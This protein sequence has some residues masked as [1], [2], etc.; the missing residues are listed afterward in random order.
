MGQIKERARFRDMGL[1]SALALSTAA[2]A[3]VGVTAA[4]AVQG[5][6]GELRNA[7]M[8]PYLQDYEIAPGVNTYIVVG[9]PDGVIGFI[10]NYGDLIVLA[11]MGLII[12][13]AIAAQAV[14]FYR[15]KLKRPLAVL[16]QASEKIAESDLD[17][18]VS[19]DQRDELGQLCVSF[20]TM[21]GAL[22]KN[23]REMWRAAEERRRINAAFSHDLRTPL[24]VLRGY[25]DLLAACI[26]LGKY[27]PEK[28]A[29][30][31]GAMSVQVNRLVRYTECMSALQRLEDMPCSWKRISFGEL[32]MRLRETAEIVCGG[33]GRRLEFQAVR[34]GPWPAEGS[35]APAGSENETVWIWADAELTAQVF[36][37]L[38]TNAVRFAETKV[39]AEC[40]LDPEGQAFCLVVTDDGPGFTE[41]GLR[42]AA[43]P[44]YRGGDNTGGQAEND[45]AGGSGSGHFGLGLH[46]SSLLCEKHGGGLCVENG[47]GGGACLTARFACVRPE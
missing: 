2:A 47:A 30:T 38:I 5:I 8:A 6:A 4:M 12:G 42:R 18:T 25:T 16:K 33:T 36:E 35:A 9:Q 22:E 14:L 10:V 27:S 1:R 45:G 39:T 17:F 11:L 32:S 29:D 26:P 13:G 34:E 23:F 15:W 37:N 31:V 43:D 20:E 19:V 28:M 41:E 21:R 46:I 24:A 7:L 40:R 44:F 3:L